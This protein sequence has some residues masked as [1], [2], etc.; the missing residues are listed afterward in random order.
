MFPDAL[1]LEADSV[2]L[3]SQLR[4]PGSI[5]IL[6]VSGH[7]L[8]SAGN[9]L[10]ASLLMTGRLGADNRYEADELSDLAVKSSVAFGSDSQPLV[11]LN[12]CQAGRGGNSIVGIGGFAAAFLKPNSGQGA[13][14]FIGAQWSVGDSTALTFAT[15]FYEALRAGRTL[16]D[17]T[18]DA[19]TA[20][21]TRV[22]SPGL[23]TRC[24]ATRWLCAQA[25]DGYE[26]GSVVAAAVVATAGWGHSAQDRPRLSA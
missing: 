23:P 22:S 25:R 8:S 26:R 14:V 9:V 6:H 3:R 2:G 5:D 13:G 1:A 20:P 10:N 18:R 16:V 12:A 11:F 7:G 19:R 17:A 15:R 24:T 21:G 4:R